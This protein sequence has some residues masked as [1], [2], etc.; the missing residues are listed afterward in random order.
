MA[1]APPCPTSF[2][3]V[4]RKCTTSKR[5]V[6]IGLDSTRVR[7]N[8]KT[9]NGTDFWREVVIRHA[10]V[11]IRSPIPRTDDRDIFFRHDFYA[12]DRCLNAAKALSRDA[13][14]STI[15]PG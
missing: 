4:V 6:Q 10:H 13:F 7:D 1:R 12:F 2:A 14:K 5:T 9:G 3:S 15:G 8:Y 11:D